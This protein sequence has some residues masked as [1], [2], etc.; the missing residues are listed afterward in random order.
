MMMSRESM[1]DVNGKLAQKGVNMTVEE[2]R[3]RPNILI[4]GR[5]NINA[6]L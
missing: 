6:Y 1:E 3:F 4:S 2:R 5:Q